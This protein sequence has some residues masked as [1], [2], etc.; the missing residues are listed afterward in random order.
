MGPCPTS[1]TQ[2]GT[3]RLRR[4]GEFLP[5]IRASQQP[6]G[7]CL[8]GPCWNKECQAG[9]GVGGQGWLL[10]RRSKTSKID[11]SPGSLAYEQSGQGYF[12]KGGLV[13]PGQTTLKIQS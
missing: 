5:Y 6:E 13:V 11:R 3:Q 7:D 1:P 10:Y 4:R 9:V 8:G 2:D 12:L